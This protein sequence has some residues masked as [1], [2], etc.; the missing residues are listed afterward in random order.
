VLQRQQPREALPL[1]ESAAQRRP[2][3]L[4]LQ[5]NYGMAAAM[6]GDLPKAVAAF[7]RVIALDPRSHEGRAQLAV[8]CAQLGQLDRAQALTQEAIQLQPQSGRYVYQL[9]MIYDAQGRKT[10][11]QQTLNRARQ[12]DPSLPL[13]G[14][15]PPR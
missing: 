12:L 15:T 1:L 14:Q 11:A 5:G 13:P 7:E 2:D 4:N 9:A 8:F 3:D 6:A 10:L